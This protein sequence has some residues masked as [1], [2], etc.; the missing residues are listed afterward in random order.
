MLDPEKVHPLSVEGLKE[1]LVQVCHE[2]PQKI[3]CLQIEWTKDTADFVLGYRN[4]KGGRINLTKL[5]RLTRDMEE[6]DFRLTHQGLAF[7]TEGLLADGQLRLTAISQLDRPTVLMTFFNLSLLD[8]AAID[9]GGGTGRTIPIPEQQ[10]FRPFL[11]RLGV[12]VSQLTT[13]QQMSYFEH[14]QD[15]F[16]WAAQNIRSK[17][18]GK[19]NVRVAFARAYRAGLH[20][21]KL[22]EFW[23]CFS[24]HC[25]I[26]IGQP[27][28]LLSLRMNILDR[29]PDIHGF[30]EKVSRLS[31][32]TLQ[33]KCLEVLLY[34]YCNGTLPTVK[35]L[36]VGVGQLDAGKL[37]TVQKP[38]EEELAWYREGFVRSAENATFCWNGLEEL[39]PN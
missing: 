8:T 2:S 37:F 18:Y 1:L 5:R 16:E 13:R 39:K 30:T 28:L 4:P 10:M 15:T 7:Q 33:C 35:S 11:R 34:H 38:T 12:R 9:D 25:D 29:A 17:Y 22:L 36:K 3:R 32:K 24:S 20:P 14:F 27:K 19:A 26:E 23:E 6:G 31:L 21:D